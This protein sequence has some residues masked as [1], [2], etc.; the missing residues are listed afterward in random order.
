MGDALQIQQVLINLLRN[1]IE[2]ISDAGLDRGSVSIEVSRGGPGFLEFEVR[3]SGPGFPSEVAT[4]T[5]E[6]LRS[7]KPYGLGV[8]LSLSRSIIEAHGGQLTFANHGAG[9][10]VRFTLPTA[11]GTH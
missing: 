9:A 1:A 7:T 10:V 8:G 3:D 11:E 6:P 5:H 2:A 4:E